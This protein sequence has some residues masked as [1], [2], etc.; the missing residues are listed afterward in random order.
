MEVPSLRDSRHY[1]RLPGASAP[2]FHIPCLRHWAGRD[3]RSALVLII[4][5]LGAFHGNAQDLV[6]ASAEQ[7]SSSDE[8][9]RGIVAVE[10][11]LVNVVEGVVELEICAEDLER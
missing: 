4:R 11:G 8:S 2:G 10:V 9:A 5:L 1:L 6:P 3:E 7:A